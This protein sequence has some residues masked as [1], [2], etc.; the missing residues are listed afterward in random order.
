M[1]VKY[2]FK[3]KRIESKESYDFIM[4]KH[5]AGRKPSISYAF[6]LFREDE[7]VGVLTIGKPVSNPLCLSCGPENKSKVFELNRL[8]TIEGLPPNTLSYFVSKVLK[9]LKSEDLIIFSYADSSMGHHGY[10][11]QATN[12]LYLGST[13]LR[14][15]KYTP[16]GKHSRH[17]KNSEDTTHLRKVRFSKYRYVFFT[18]RSKKEYLSL[19]KYDILEYP[20]GENGSYDDS[21]VYKDT[22]L[23]RTKGESLKTIRD[24]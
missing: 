21:F 5:Y 4:N 11:Y 17:Y 15:D 6:G 9:L 12:W 2:E 10:I 19:L 18:G 1:G 13:T 20:K 8:Y 14:T 16:D 23:D 24:K 3:V 7:M 22:I